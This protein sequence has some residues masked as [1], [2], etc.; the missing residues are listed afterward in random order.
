MTTYFRITAYEPQKDYCCIID[1]YG[2]Y[3]KLW[4]FSSYLVSRGYK[5]LE[6]SPKERFENGNIRPLTEPHPDM[7]YIRATNKGRPIEENLNGQRVIHVKDRYYIPE[8]E[9]ITKQ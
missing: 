8:K 1:A 2:M 5:I 3:D 4:Q 6:A 9:Y 7:F